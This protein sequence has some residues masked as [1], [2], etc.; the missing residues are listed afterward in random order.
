MTTKGSAQVCFH[1]E[2][3]TRLL[4]ASPCRGLAHVLL[5]CPHYRC[6]VSMPSCADIRS[7]DD[8]AAWKATG[9]AA[10]PP[11]FLIS[12]CC[13]LHLIPL[14][15]LA[16]R[17]AAADEDWD[18][19][20]WSKAPAI[21]ETPITSSIISPSPNDSVP[22]GRGSLKVKGYAFAGGGREV[23]RVDVSADGG[24][25]W[26]AASLLPP[27]EGM[28]QE[29]RKHWAWRHWEVHSPSSMFYFLHRTA[30][31]V[32]HTCAN[33]CVIYRP[34]QGMPLGVSSGTCV[35]PKVVSSGTCAGRFACQ[36]R[37]HGGPGLQSCGR[38]V[39][40]SA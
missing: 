34:M 20:D 9:Y 22:A 36:E 29:Y 21:Q 31:G 24:K 5:L 18:H 7:I 17:S 3:D 25:T 4:L 28:E 8:N 19:L 11:A 15:A 26:R 2:S 27:P 14:S 30:A 37:L 13:Y 33:L 6:C 23:I 38:L 40:R 39:Q 32:E 16:W 12:L 1:A 35:T 10:V